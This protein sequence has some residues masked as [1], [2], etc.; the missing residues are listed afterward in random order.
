MKG[1]FYKM[2]TIAW[3]LIMNIIFFF[4]GEDISFLTLGDKWL[5]FGAFAILTG[6]VLRGIHIKNRLRDKTEQERYCHFCFFYST[7]CMLLLIVY[8]ALLS[9]LIQG[10]FI[11]GKTREFSDIF[12]DFSGILVAW[13]V[14]LL[15]TCWERSREIISSS[16]KA[17][18]KIDIKT[19]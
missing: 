18:I 10:Y 13:G 6:L 4:P 5:H 17:D 14:S 8:F 7:R 12:I 3:F 11:P 2:A 19:K 15:F 1:K 9:E 16:S